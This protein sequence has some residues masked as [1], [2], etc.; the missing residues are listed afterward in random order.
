MPSTRD[1]LIMTLCYYKS[2]RECKTFGTSQNLQLIY[3]SDCQS[4]EDGNVWN[5]VSCSHSTPITL[6]DQLIIVGGHDSHGELD[7]VH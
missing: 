7:I 6:H 1:Q 4:E 3:S 2:S 5:P